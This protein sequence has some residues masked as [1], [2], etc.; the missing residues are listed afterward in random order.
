MDKILPNL[1]RIVIWS[2]IYTRGNKVIFEST[3]YYIWTELLVYLHSYRSRDIFVQCLSATGQTTIV[4]W[5][6]EV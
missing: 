3:I 5:P 4:C 6:M 2:I 1:N